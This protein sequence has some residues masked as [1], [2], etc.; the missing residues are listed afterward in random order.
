[1]QLEKGQMAYMVVA[2]A[3]ENSDSFTIF[4]IH[5]G[6]KNCVHVARLG[7]Q[8]C[9]PGVMFESC[10]GGVAELKPGGSHTTPQPSSAS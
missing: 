7:H 4:N 9:S 1:M 3:C 2:Y 5:G 10:L 6:E 8:V